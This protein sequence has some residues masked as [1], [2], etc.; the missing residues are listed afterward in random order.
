MTIAGGGSYGAQLHKE[1]RE[2]VTAKEKSEVVLG[3]EIT[4]GGHR[5]GDSY[6]TGLRLL[7]KD[8]DAKGGR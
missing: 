6:W 1:G 8:V 3:W 7:D 4:E 5:E 2:G